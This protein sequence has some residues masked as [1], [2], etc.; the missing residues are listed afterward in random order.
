M[1]NESL[2]G[3]AFEKL[4]HDI[5]NQLSNIQLALEGMRFEVDEQ[6]SDIALYLD[7]MAQSAKKI[8]KLLDGFEH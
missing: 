3:E 1:A 2:N 6:N 7:S 8:D 5:R 4:K